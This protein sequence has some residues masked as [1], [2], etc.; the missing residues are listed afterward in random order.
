M[1][2][3]LNLTLKIWRQDGP[4][5]A[6]HFDVIA[7]PGINDEMSFLEMLDLV[8]ERLINEGKEAIVKWGQIQKDINAQAA[9]VPKAQ[10]EQNEQQTSKDKANTEMEA[11]RRKFEA[12]R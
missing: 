1:S 6:G 10:Q 7:A 2:K 4:N 5:A 3:E 11:L 9:N 12:I 8:N